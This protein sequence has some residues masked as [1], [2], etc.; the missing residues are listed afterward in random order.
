MMASRVPTYWRTMVNRI[1]GSPRSFTKSTAPKM[2][3]SVATPQDLMNADRGRSSKAML[4]GEF[5]PVYVALGLITVSVSLGLLTAKQELLYSPNVFL[6][7]KRRESVPEVN[8]PD[9]VFDEVDKFIH[10]SLFRKVAHIQDVD[11]D[12]RVA[13]TNSKKMETLKSLGVDPAAH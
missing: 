12:R 8:D 3:A 4:K 7:K 6:S 2:K 9:Y 13:L 5:F 11:R 10:K 1:G